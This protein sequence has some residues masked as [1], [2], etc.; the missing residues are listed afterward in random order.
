MIFS[1]I[2]WKNNKTEKYIKT[3]SVQSIDLKFFLG[4][5]ILN[6]VNINNNKNRLNMKKDKSLESKLEMIETLNLINKLNIYR[7]KTVDLLQPILSQMD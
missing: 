1:K 3:K 4:Q 7:M 5:T 2:F 6:Q